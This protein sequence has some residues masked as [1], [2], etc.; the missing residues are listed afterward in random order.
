[1]H[2]RYKSKFGVKVLSL[3]C[4]NL[5]KNLIHHVGWTQEADAISSIM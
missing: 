2:S 4:Y 3:L 5:L 1:M